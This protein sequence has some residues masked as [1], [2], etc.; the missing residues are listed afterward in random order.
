[1]SVADW[2]VY[3]DGVKSEMVLIDGAMAGVFLKKGYSEIEFNYVNK[4]LIPGIMISLVSLA[5]FTVLV[6]YNFL[7]KNKKFPEIA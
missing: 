1:M 5:I 4:S 7:K 3:V 6:I 2:T